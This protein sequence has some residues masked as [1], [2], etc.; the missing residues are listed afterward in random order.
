MKKKEVRR[1]I[2]IIAAKEKWLV[3]NGFRKYTYKGRVYFSYK[4]WKWTQKYVRNT[5]AIVLMKSKDFKDKKITK[6]ELKAV[7]NKAKK[8]KSKRVA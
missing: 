5:P 8:I 3:N 2:D 1:T 4:N 7:M 6:E